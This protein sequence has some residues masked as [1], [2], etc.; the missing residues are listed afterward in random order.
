MKGF[1]I[2]FKDNQANVKILPEVKSIDDLFFAS[3][4]RGWFISKGALYMTE[5][6]ET[7]GK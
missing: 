2:H 3:E 1:L 4:N 6:G 5:D 7:D